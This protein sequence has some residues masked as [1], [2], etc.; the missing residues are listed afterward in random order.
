MRTILYAIV[1][2]LTLAS[3]VIVLVQAGSRTE[4]PPAEDHCG[5]RVAP[6]F[7]HG[8]G[9]CPGC[10]SESWAVYLIED[11]ILQIIAR[12]LGR[13][14]IKF[15]EL[16][17][18]CDVVIPRRYIIGEEGGKPFIVEN[19][20]KGRRLVVDAFDPKRRIAIEFVSVADHGELGGAESPY[21]TGWPP[22][23]EDTA[24]FLAHRLWGEG[25]KGVY[26]GIFYDP[27][28]RS[29]QYETESNAENPSNLL[30]KKSVENLLRQVNDFVDWLK[31]E[32]AI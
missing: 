2:L 14:G 4:V 5:S 28:S 3:V 15:P 30:G 27:V 12:E 10:C 18:E 21:S 6:V 8:D 17:V 23:V 31:A 25:M 20:K 24:K 16:N 1:I 32:G 19:Y 11:E 29:D 13:H 22:D 7:E 26:F 9:W